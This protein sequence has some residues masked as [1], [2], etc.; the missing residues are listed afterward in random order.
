MAKTA[1]HEQQYC[2]A[3]EDREDG[4]RKAVTIGGMPYRSAFEL[5]QV[6][7]KSRSYKKQYRYFHVAKFPYRTHKNT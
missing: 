5:K 2:V 3:A 7:S 4:F 6:Y 1:E